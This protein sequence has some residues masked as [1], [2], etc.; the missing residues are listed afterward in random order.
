MNKKDNNRLED[1]DYNEWGNIGDPNAFNKS[2][3]SYAK[4]KKLR[5]QRSLLNKDPAWKKKVNEANNNWSAER[6]KAYQNRDRSYLEEGS[7]FRKNIAKMNHKSRIPVRVKKPG[8]K[9]IT[10]KSVKAFAETTE[11]TKMFQGN[12]RYYFPKDMSIKTI[13]HS[14]SPYKGWQFQRLVEE[15]AK[16]RK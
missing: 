16:N 5:K 7:E 15:Q 4:T 1:F 6:M 2:N 13:K 14:K 10:Y 9:W 12:P 11:D 3:Y 8:G